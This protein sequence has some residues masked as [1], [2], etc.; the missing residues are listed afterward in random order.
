MVL[1]KKRK[2]SELMVSKV[3][4]DF[5]SLLIE[6]YNSRLSLVLLLLVY[7]VSSFRLSINICKGKVDSLP[8]ILHLQIKI[9]VLLHMCSA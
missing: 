3:L 2:K 8:L 9:H 5:T 7:F 4:P 1:D 6:R